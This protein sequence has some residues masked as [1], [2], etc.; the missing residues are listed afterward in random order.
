MLGSC[1]RPSVP[2]YRTTGADASPMRSRHALFGLHTGSSSIGAQLGITV[3]L[4][5]TPHVVSVSRNV[6]E[7]ATTAA[8]ERA[9]ARSTRSARTATDSPTRGTFFR[10]WS[11][12]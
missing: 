5:A 9:T 6:G 12:M 10:A 11:P 2:E 7:M 1:L 8:D 4:W 3:V